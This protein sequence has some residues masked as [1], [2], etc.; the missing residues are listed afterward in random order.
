MLYGL[1]GDPLYNLWV[2]SQLNG[3][4]LVVSSAYQNPDPNHI[5]L[6]AQPLIDFQGKIFSSLF[7]PTAAYNI[8]IALGFILTFLAAY[9]IATKITKNRFACLFSALI[10]TLLPYRLIHSQLHIN[11]SSTQWLLFFI[12][13]LISLREK[14]SLWRALS[15]GIFAVLTMLDNYQYAAF[16]VLCVVVFVVYDFFARY[17]YNQLK[18]FYKNIYLMTVSFVLFFLMVFIFDRKIIDAVFHG[19]S[20]STLGPERDI[21]ELRTYSAFW[22]YYLTPSPALA[23]L[24]EPFAPIFAE[25]INQLK[26]NVAE[27]TIFLGWIP[28]GMA[29]F[30]IFRIRDKKPNF[31]VGYFIALATASILLSLI[32]DIRVGSFNLKPP[33]E[34]IFSQF[35]IIRVY[36]RLGFLVGVSVSMI[37]GWSLAYIIDKKNTAKKTIIALILSLLVIVEF[38]PAKPYPFIDTR[39]LPKIYEELKKQPPGTLVEYPLLP[40]EEPAS[41][42]YLLTQLDH[43]MPLVYGSSPNT[44]GDE[45]RKTILNPSLPETIKNLRLNDVMYMIVHKDRY[46]YSDTSKYPLEYNEG[47][48]PEINHEDLSLITCQE[49]KCLYVLD[50][51]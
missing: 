20:F 40:A 7:G 51:Q 4:N 41:Y 32:F 15:L 16:A 11:L 29:L 39:D 28:V 3:A 6:P 17:K 9:L 8:I 50:N 25:K 31:N 42:E 30:S 23:L 45:L 47:V 12:F 19:F 27:Q 22:F 2:F 35:P 48:I 13:S 18:K 34:I 33:S 10:V 21:L 26:T 43:R 36:S 1:N 5:L 37:A 14:P 49:L 24:S 38:M 46:L 44:K